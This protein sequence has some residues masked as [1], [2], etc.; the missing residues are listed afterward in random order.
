MELTCCKCGYKWDYKGKL[1]FG[2]NC[3]GCHRKNRVWIKENLKYAEVSNCQHCGKKFTKKYHNSKYCSPKCQRI[4]AA[5]LGARIL[6]SKYDF[7]GK[8]NPRWKGGISKNHYHYKK[9][10]MERHPERVKARNILNKA[11]D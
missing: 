3:P 9:I 6:H 5:K 8:N 11:I 10:Q 7:S 2:P 1:A 4:E